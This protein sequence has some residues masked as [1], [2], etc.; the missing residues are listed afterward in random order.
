MTFDIHQMD[1]IDAM[2]ED[3]EEEFNAY[4]DQLAQ[5]FSESPE[6]KQHREKYR[7]SIWWADMFMDLAFRYLGESIP[8][9]DVGGVDELV[10]DLL[11]RKVSLQSR[12]EALDA[13]PE[14]LAFWSFLQREYQLGNASE[15]LQYLE[16]YS[17]DE[18]ANSMLDPS[19]AGMAKSFFL[20]GQNAGFDM[21]DKRQIDEYMLLHNTSQVLPIVHEQK[22]KKKAATKEKQKRKAEKAARKR[23]RKR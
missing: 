6:G 13:I 23:N 11:P 12:A 5:L 4:R 19:K 3:G 15:I 7:D 2:S 10:T 21:T 16:S 22:T 20:S 8:S 14:L 18:F 9:L 1:E 17:P